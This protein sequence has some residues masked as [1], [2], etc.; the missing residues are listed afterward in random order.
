MR[1]P[2]YVLSAVV[3][4]FL[5]APLVV[6][7]KGTL[8]PSDT[9][10]TAPCPDSSK[11]YRHSWSEPLVYAAYAESEE[12]LVHASYLAESIR[13]FGGR[14]AHAPIRVYV[15]EDLVP[16]VD[17][18]I[19][20]LE[21][22]GVCVVATAMPLEYRG[23]PFGGK[24]YAAA[25]AERETAGKAMILVWLDEDTIVLQEPGAFLLGARTDFAYRPVMHNRSGSLFGQPP[26]PFWARV[27]ELLGVDENM[28]FA[29][30]TP[31]DHQQ[32]RP[33]FNAGL[34]VVRPERGILRGWAEA[35]ETLSGDPMLVAL[36][37]QDEVKRIFLH[38]AALVGPVLRG[39]QRERM[40]ELPGAYNYPLFFKQMY[41]AAEEFDSIGEVVSLRYDKYFQ[42]PEPDWSRRLR[43]EPEK[44][45]WLAKRLGKR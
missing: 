28:F 14:N 43:G 7:A 25:Q 8:S 22:W 26:D 5:L 17:S 41:G 13:A 16:S 33:Y 6:L 31:A 11:E 19:T 2:V 36:C 18:M 3:T 27:Y 4:V 38:Q 45:T 24:V 37:G 21:S 12:Q 9:A 34:L 1:L 35:F 10:M 39:V 44:I 20:I 15:P 40:V 32:I 30:E 23:W 42:H 29:M